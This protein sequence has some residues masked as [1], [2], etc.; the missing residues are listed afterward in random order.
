MVLLT[1]SLNLIFI[2]AALLAANGA[3]ASR[4][5]FLKM[6]RNNGPPVG[7]KKL[8][9]RGPRP[10][11]SDVLPIEP[12]IEHPSILYDPSPEDLNIKTLR[13]QIGDEF[14]RRF[15]SVRDPRRRRNKSLTKI[16]RPPALRSRSKSGKGG[17]HTGGIRK[18]PSFFRLLRS[19]R[20]Q[21]GTKIRLDVSKRERRIFQKYM[22][23][24]T[25]CPVKFTWRELS[26]RF[27]P[28]WI[29]EGRC[30]NRR[31]CSVPAGMTCKPS[32]FVYKTLLRWVCNPARRKTCK[33]V[34][35]SYPIIT[36]CS[37]SCDQTS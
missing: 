18:R 2:F 28:R 36:E 15:M 3:H 19:A 26:V 21:D 25:F 6:R 12:L 35:I 8:P 23:N 20:L 24:L 22:W 27:W 7:Q 34:N 16:T 29:R 32:K 5:L 13:E 9:S 1:P 31:S 11:S 14:D 4:E 17:K 30:V 37:C 10:I 33:W